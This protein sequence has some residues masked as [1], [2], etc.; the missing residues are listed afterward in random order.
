MD[1]DN[2]DLKRE[3]RAEGKEWLSVQEAA[4]YLAVSQPTVFRWMK[5][6]VLSFYKVGASTRFSREGLDAVIEK[7]TGR[8]EAEAA[9]SRCAACG[10]GVLAEGSLQGLGRIYFRPSKVRFWA[11]AEALVPTLC[12]VCT[13]CGYVQLH[14][15]TGKLK[16]LSVQA[17]ES[18]AETRQGDTFPSA[19][20]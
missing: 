10:H 16:R 17:T 11:M 12:R 19:G 2:F 8:K 7:R 6:G 1:Q 3:D 9:F 15:D 5:Q 20:I 14:A 18:G 4:D 13:A